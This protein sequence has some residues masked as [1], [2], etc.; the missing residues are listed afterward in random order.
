MK[1]K[2]DKN[3]FFNYDVKFHV[4]INPDLGMMNENNVE[5]VFRYMRESLLKQYQEDLE[6][7][8]K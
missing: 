1:A 3:G 8:G 6:E 2:I 4:T 5:M 7:Y